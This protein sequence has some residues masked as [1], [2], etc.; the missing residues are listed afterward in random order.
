MI[1]KGLTVTVTIS[2][3]GV[4]KGVDRDVAEEVPGVIVEVEEYSELV[5]VW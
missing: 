3:V 4:P 1:V 5:E 2:Q